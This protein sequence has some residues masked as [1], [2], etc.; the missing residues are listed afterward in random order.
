MKVFNLTLWLIFFSASSFMADPCKEGPVSVLSR[1]MDIFYFKVCKDFIGARI[2]IYS[3]DGELLV[4][5]EI[6]HP[7]AL[8][9]FYFEKPGDYTIK[10]VKDDEEESFTYSKLTPPPLVVAD[11]DYQIVISQQ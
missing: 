7:K 2:E 10:F 1:K 8:V 9:D 4:A 5:D 6:T 11:F 3:P